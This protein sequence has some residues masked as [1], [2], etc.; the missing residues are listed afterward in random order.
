MTTPLY[1]NNNPIT[2]IQDI[3]FTYGSQAFHVHPYPK[4]Q[5][6]VFLA[7]GQVENI[8]DAPVKT[9]WKSGAFQVGSTQ[10]AVKRLHRDMM[11]G[12]HIKDTANSYEFNESAFRQIFDYQIDPL[13]PAGTPTTL[14]VTTSISGTRSLNVLLSEAPVFHASQDPI[15]DQY[16]NLILKLR[17]G[18]PM[19]YQPSVTSTFSGSTTNASGFITV[20]NPT[21]QTM[22][23]KWVLTLGTFTIPDF[24]WIGA[25]GQRVP[26][27]TNG[28]RVITLA[29]V[30]ATNGGAVID[31]DGSNLMIRDANNTNILGQ[32]QVASPPGAFFSYPIPPYTPPTLL[33]VAYTNA[34][35]GGAMIQL[36]QPLTWSRPWGLE[37][38]YNTPLDTH[39]TT[40]L[41][42]VP[43][44]YTMQ[45][46]PSADTFD[47]IIVGAGGG[48]G[49]GGTGNGVGGLAGTW[50]AKTFVRGID[51]PWST[52]QITGVIG[53]GGVAGTV[54][55]ILAGTGGTT[56]ATDVSTQVNLSAAG[57]A[58]AGWTSNVN[59]QGA[60]TL[61]F[62]GNSYLGG[63]LASIGLPG[64]VSGGAGAGGWPSQNGG[65]GA[66][67]AVWLY[68]YQ[69]GGGS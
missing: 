31:L 62:A 40:S 36:I 56:T 53:T 49:A 14:N 41:L 46:P 45:I 23:Q 13:D 27:G 28:T 10:K 22:Y 15:K 61:A 48:G 39:P 52:T 20:T 37:L 5:Q 66:A 33:P 60:G 2:T 6:G 42:N 65:V 63:A 4:C 34:P 17:A 59:G 29:P 1:S 50:R 11:L 54:S 7:E 30:T 47:L 24:Q 68:A 57:G 32:Q 8:Y 58:G 44:S 12:F 26:G 51:V 18:S 16:S 55:G 3:Y 19:W 25:K 69:T 43:G 64:N 38:A 67:G 21:D 35:A 9:T